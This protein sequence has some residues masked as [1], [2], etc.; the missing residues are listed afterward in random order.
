MEFAFFSLMSWVK[1]L[2]IEQSFNFSM[3]KISYY[4]TCTVWDEWLTYLVVVFTETDEMLLEAT[5]S[6]L[7]AVIQKLSSAGSQKVCILNK[8]VQAI[9]VLANKKNAVI[10]ITKFYFLSKNYRYYWCE[11]LSLKTVD[12]GEVIWRN[13]WFNIQTKHQG[14]VSKLLMG[15]YFFSL[16]AARDFSIWPS[17][18]VQ[19][20]S[21]LSAGWCEGQHCTNRSHS[22][23]S[24]QQASWFTQCWHPEG[25]LFLIKTSVTYQV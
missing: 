25:W 19:H 9:H 6:A 10:V 21:L 20:W 17:V 5:T 24:V 11:L 23:C 1:T 4:S 2:N 7:R 15:I 18:P 3:T 8:L 16:S 14:C 12:F 13:F 22:G